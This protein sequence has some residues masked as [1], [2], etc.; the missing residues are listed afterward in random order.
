[1]GIPACNIVWLKRDLR[2]QDHAALAAAE[3]ENTPYFII[4][5]FESELMA[6]PDTSTRHLQ[7]CYHSLLEMQVTLG[8]SGQRVE[9]MYGEAV[10]VFEWF[11]QHFQVEQVFSYQES[12]VMKTWI[13]D[14]AVARLFKE[15]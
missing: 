9:V 12:G 4:F 5:L 8:K 3:A 10:A 14:K 6:L 2:T 15:S 13:R 1:M 11:A 7:F